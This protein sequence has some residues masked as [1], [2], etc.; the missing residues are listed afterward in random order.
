MVSGAGYSGVAV[1]MIVAGV[2]IGVLV[3]VIIHQAVMFHAERRRLA[4]ENSD[5]FNRLMARDFREYASGGRA[6]A[7]N[8]KTISEYLRSEKSKKREETK[9][10]EADGLGMSVI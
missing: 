5:L 2:V 7:T 8:R 6:I 4:G 9:E 1:E 3:H 10:D